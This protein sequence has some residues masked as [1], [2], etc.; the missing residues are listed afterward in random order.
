M[1]R[2]RVAPPSEA[3]IAAIRSEISPERPPTRD[4]LGAT[5]PIAQI[6]GEA[7]Q[8]PVEEIRR[9]RETAEGHRAAAEE[10]AA[11]VEGER[12]LLDLP[13]EAVR[14]DYLTR[15]R[16]GAT[17]VVEQDLALRESLRVHGQRTPIEVVALPG[18]ADVYGLVSGWRRLMA[19]EALLS[20]TGESRFATVRAVVRSGQSRA[21]SF[22]GMVE[23]NEVRLNLSFYERGRICALSARDGVFPDVETAVCALF[24]SA[25]EA[26]RSKVRSF[27][28]VHDAL[29]DVLRFP[30][31]LS[32]R[33]GLTL[34]KALKW[35]AEPRIREGLVAAQRDGQIVSPEDEHRV[36]ARL[37]SLKPS[38]S[39][40]ERPPAKRGLDPTR[41]RIEALGNGLRLEQRCYGGFTD[42]RIVGEDIDDAQ[43]ERAF[44][45][46]RALLTSEST[47]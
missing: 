42:L 2:K 34:A 8:A 13:L 7:A 11:A 19:L 43:L 30:Q 17:E 39:P 15:D 40:A 47:R 28:L 36:I 14:R 10:H 9:L 32:E 41:H 16:L 25:S 12:L 31:T 21:A 35:Q 6:V 26:K 38:A 24:R 29:A 27:V 37:C 5:A 18:E 23:E 4:L 22:V 20:E 45:A 33:L 1:A 44:D 3:E 46:L